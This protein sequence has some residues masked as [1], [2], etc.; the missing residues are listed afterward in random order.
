MRRSPCWLLDQ[1]VGGLG[2]WNKGKENRSYCGILGLYKENGKENGS[3]YLGIL[4]AQ[5][6][7]LRLYGL[8]FIQVLQSVFEGFESGGLG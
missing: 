6:S 3:Y 5:D 4:G 1:T 8:R 2:F 7:G